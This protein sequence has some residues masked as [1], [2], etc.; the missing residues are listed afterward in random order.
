MIPIL[1]IYLFAQVATRGRHS[2]AGMYLARY[3]GGAKSER[4]PPWMED[5]RG[6]DSA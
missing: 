4:V 1:F 2:R 6:A 3:A 5:R